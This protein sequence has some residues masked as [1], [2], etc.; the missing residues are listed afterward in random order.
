MPIET[1]CTGCGQ[2]MRVADG[3]AGKQARCPV[4]NTISVI[5]AGSARGSPSPFPT[6]GGMSADEPAWSMQTP[7]GQIYGPVP[8][9]E[10][11]RWLAE[12]RVTADCRLKAGG[13]ST[14]QSADEVYPALRPGAYAGGGQRSYAGSPYGSSGSSAAGSLGS[15]SSPF[16]STEP[17][18]NSSAR[19]THVTPH[20]GAII[21]VLGIMGWVITCPI[22]A[23]MAWVM[24][25][26]DLREM[27]SGRMDPSGMGLTQAGQILGMIYSMLW[28]LIFLLFLFIILIGVAAAAVA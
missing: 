9:A 8:K 10:L 26:G 27:R 24:G 13:A 19:S 6:G 14:W 12:G 15:S 11:D 2:R 1:N 5:P 3:H 23:I 28:I 17:Q 18:W 20:R 7:E 21:F 16:G 22:L 25:S 4:C